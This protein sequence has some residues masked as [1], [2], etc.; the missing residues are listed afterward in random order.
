[1]CQYCEQESVTNASGRKFGENIPPLGG[2]GDWEI[3]VSWRPGCSPHIYVN[4]NDECEDVCFEIN[5]CPMCG[6]N[7][8]EAHH[9]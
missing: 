2:Y 7:L 6:R 1:M 5:Y 9:A 3:N 8:K 4:N